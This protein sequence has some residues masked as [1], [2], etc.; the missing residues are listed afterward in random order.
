MD[1]KLFHNSILAFTY[2]FD[3]FVFFFTIVEMD[4]LGVNYIGSPYG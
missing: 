2:R 4:N 1:V 3:R